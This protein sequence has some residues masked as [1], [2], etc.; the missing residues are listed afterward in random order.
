MHVI[1]DIVHKGGQ[2]LN[3][4]GGAL[5]DIMNIVKGKQAEE[6][7]DPT[8]GEPDVSG[9]GEDFSP[10]EGGDTQQLFHQE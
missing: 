8:G 5:K 1:H 7:T 6:P 10:A 3:R 2:I 4:V 9:G